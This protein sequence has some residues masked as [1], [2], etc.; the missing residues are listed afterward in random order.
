[1]EKG[2]SK[3]V[4][5]GAGTMGVQ[6]GALCAGRDYIVYVYD[7][8]SDVLEKVPQRL[9][10][11]F[12]EMLVSGVPE[13]KNPAKS[14]RNV[15]LAVDLRHACIDADLLIESVSEDE[16]QKHR[17]FRAVSDYCSETAILATNSSSFIPSMFT[18]DCRHPRRLAALHF[19][20]PVW[21]CRVV[22][23]MPHVGTEPEVVSALTDFAK[24]LGQVVIPY[25]RET[26]GYVFN[27]LL[28][29]VQRQAL[30]L[31]ISGIANF[32]DVD[33]AWMGITHMEIGPF[34]MI[35][36][37]GLDTVRDIF[38]YWAK[39][40]SDPA[41]HRRVLFLNDFVAKAHLGAKTGQ[42]FYSYPNPSYHRPN[43]ARPDPAAPEQLKIAGFRFSAL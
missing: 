13:G 30:D 16:E 6:I 22:D 14:L 1:M 23:V 37:I 19:H 29:S 18:Q 3:I 41:A 12:S 7:V 27:A 8:N 31:V 39:K 9:E 34:G 21:V 42:G 26:Y 36:Q 17:V 35:D 24:S 43:F 40:L 33:R 2:I 10:H 20:L 25:A 15:H 28:G 4:L 38:A 5:V 32:E 11:I